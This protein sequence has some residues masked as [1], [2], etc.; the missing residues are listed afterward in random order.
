MLS[1]IRSFTERSDLLPARPVFKM[2]LVSGWFS[3]SAGVKNAEAVTSFFS[4]V[5][6]RV[7]PARTAGG[8]AE[9]QGPAT[10]VFRDSTH[11]CWQ[12]YAERCAGYARTD[13]QAGAG[14]NAKFRD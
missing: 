7:A 10:P 13:D 6:S 12:D 4:T 8:C 9:T 1:P 11:E 3:V 2:L 5:R 14:D